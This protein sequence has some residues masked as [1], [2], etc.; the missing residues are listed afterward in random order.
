MLLL[1]LLAGCAPETEPLDP[2]CT[3]A[4]DTLVTTCA[5]EAFPDLGSCQSGCR[6]AL[7]EGADMPSYARCVDLAACDPFAL[8]ACEH[9]YGLD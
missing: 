6:Y 8:V 9:D 3:D 5:I 2:A 1:L 4:C 7:Q